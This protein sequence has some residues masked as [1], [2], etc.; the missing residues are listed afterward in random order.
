MM[1][2]PFHIF[3]FYIPLTI[4]ISLIVKYRDKFAK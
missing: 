1:E 2:L 4:G 3:S